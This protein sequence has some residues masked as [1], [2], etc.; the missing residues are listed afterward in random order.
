M[1]TRPHWSYSSINQFLRCPAQFYFERI[2]K[3]PRE[4]VGSGL[5]LGSAVHAALAE[6]HLGLMHKR[7]TSRDQ[8]LDTF[9]NSWKTRE[10]ETKID[11]RKGET[12]SGLQ[13]VGVNL[14]ELYLEQPPPENIIAVEQRMLAP[15]H[16]SH[17]EYLETPLLAFADLITE[18]EEGITIG[19]LK[20]SGRA[21]SNLEAET[22]LQPTC[23][24]TAAQEN[25]GKP[26]TVNYTILIKNKKP[27]VQRLSAVRY[28]EDLGRLGD[29]VEAIERAIQAKAFY[30]VETPLNCSTCPFRAPCREWKPS[31]EPTVVS[32][33]SNIPS[34]EVV[35]C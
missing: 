6:Y 22:S 20:T 27:R 35:T 15:I 1:F 31:G 9:T 3:L 23:Y 30:P 12:R 25:Y 24:I 19:E 10:D 29:T 16:N 32:L 13:E 11:Y 28:P 33:N 8:I 4:T 7:E 2:L 14:L 17:G 5:V 26:A 18:T 34:T 21:Y